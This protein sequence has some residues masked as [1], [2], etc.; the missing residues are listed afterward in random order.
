MSVSASQPLKQYSPILV[1]L[2]ISIFVR[3]EQDAKLPPLI[4]LTLGSSMDVREVQELKQLSP[5]V[6][7]LGISMDVRLAH[8]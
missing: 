4:V 1:A 6:V 2:S 5:S 7:T 8:L 3:F